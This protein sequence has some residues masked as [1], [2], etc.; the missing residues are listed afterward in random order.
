MIRGVLYSLNA[1][2]GESYEDEEFLDSPVKMKRRECPELRAFIGPGKWRTRVLEAIRLRVKSEVAA[3][4]PRNEYPDVLKLIRTVLASF[5]DKPVPDE[6]PEKV[7]GILDR[8][9]NFV[10]SDM[11][12]KVIQEAYRR[13][14]VQAIIANSIIPARFY[15]DH[16]TQSGASQY[17]EAII[18]SSDLEVAKPD[19]AIFEFALEALQFNPDELI[20][21]ADSLETD[22]MGGVQMGIKTILLNRYTKIPVVP[23][24]VEVVQ[25]FRQLIS[26][27][28]PL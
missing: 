16:F 17:F 25:D 21:V 28:P 11:T 22:V 5:S 26:K 20:F 8:F 19:P 4:K 6:L 24:G 23:K 12:M 27:L 3:G 14:Y 18:T 15:S 13:N 10:F 7:L 9:S 1:L 2:M